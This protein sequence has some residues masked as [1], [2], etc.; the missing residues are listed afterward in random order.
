MKKNIHMI[1]KISH[2]CIYVLNQDEAYDFYVNK[3]GFEVRTDAP[4]DEGM[5]WLTVGP[6]EQPDIEISLMP[7]REGMMFTKENS[8]T[9]ER[10]D[11]QGN[12]WFWC[13]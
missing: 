4:M 1:T 8:G 11:P 9:D 7:V 10:T 2:V 3:L 13:I 12:I 5:R 6:K